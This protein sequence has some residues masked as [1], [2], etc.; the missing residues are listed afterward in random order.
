DQREKQDKPSQAVVIVSDRM[1]T[2]GRIT[3]FE[4]EIPKIA[5]IKNLTVALIAGD[6]LR[7]SNVVN[8]T[9]RT[10]P[11][12][13]T[14]KGIAET[15]AAQYVILR[16]NQIETEIFRPRGFS[17]ADFYTGK[18]PGLHQNLSIQVDQ[19]VAGF[20]FRVDLIVAGLDDSGA[21]VFGIGN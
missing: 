19:Q 21:H 5:L 7:G 18:V 15:A 11:A 1:V 6:A 13:P 4:H 3:E 14:V 8:E 10:A 17:R 12:S 20:N 16:Q 2:M 9:I